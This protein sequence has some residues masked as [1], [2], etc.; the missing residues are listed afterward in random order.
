L[1][2]AARIDPKAGAGAWYRD[3]GGGMGAAL[4]AAAAM[5]AY[6]LSDRG[7]WISFKNKGP[8]KIVIEGDPALLNRYDVIELNPKTY[9][10]A[11]LALAHQLWVWLSTKPGQDA[12]GAY[13]LGG[14]ELFHPSAANPK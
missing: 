7:T 12:I 9:P 4:N 6:T 3:I 2:K 5:P 10:T 8:L 13:R 1:W 14:E 11:K